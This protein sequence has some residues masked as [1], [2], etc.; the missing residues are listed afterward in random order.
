MAL[1]KTLEQA[2]RWITIAGVF[3]LPFIV[4]IVSSS[5][6]FPFITGK[7]FAFRIIVEIITGS[8]LALALI[9]PHYRPRRNW[10]LAAFALFAIIMAVAD[11]QGVN[12]FK[13]F[14]SNFER[15]DGWV[16]L[17]HLFLYFTV[18]SSILTDKLWK[19][20]WHVILGSSLLI[21]GYGFL[22]LAGL[23]TIN[24]G[25]VRLDATFGNATYLAVYMLFML[26]LAGLFW[27]RSW[28]E[29]GP[30]RRMG[31]GLVYGA[32]MLI[33]FIIMF[34][35]ATR[36]A[37]LGVLGGAIL[38]A[39]LLVLQHPRSRYA[40]RIG[41]GIAAVVVLSLGFW[42][43]RGSSWVQRIEPLQRIASISLS[44]DT[45][46]SR[47]MNIGMALK[48]FEE[49]PL[50]GWGQENYAI[51]FDKY[52]NPDMY[53]QEPWFDRVHN[54]VFD[55]LVAGGLLGLLGY[56][57]LYA[58]AL[59]ALWRSAA[60]SAIERSII[61]GLLAG[62]LFY[63]LFT[64]DNVTSYI[65]FATVLAYIAFR[66]SEHAGAKRLWEGT[67]AGGGSALPFT[68]IGAVILVW[69]GAWFVNADALAQ[70]RTLL[71]AIAPQQD[72]SQNLAYF[73]QAASYQ[74]PGLQEVREQLAQAAS[75]LA[76][77]SNIPADM[78]Q[79]FFTFAVDQM[80]AQSNVSP[81]DARFPLFLGIL[82]D[83]YGDYGDGQ[84]ALARAHE[85]SPAKQSILFQQ[86]ADAE[87]RGDTA[88][89]LQFLK[90][91]FDLAPAYRDARLYY[92]AVLIKANRE[93]DAQQVL[94]PLMQTGEAADPRIAA[95]YAARG[96][97][98]KIAALWEAHVAAQPTDMQ[99]YFTLAA[100]YYA[101][102]NSSQAIATLQKAEKQ[103]PSIASQAEQFI[104]QIR[105]G[106][107]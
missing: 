41:V 12:P 44:D 36:G 102:G 67:I 89:E 107:K 106:K 95:A 97:Y 75:Q 47:L 84:K 101:E 103:D 19:Y 83:S 57:S 17:A 33:D 26:F 28:E 69:A 64:F 46:A 13:S 25:G 10:Q 29:N 87:A 78:K 93:A 8:W 80:I 68:T 65:L 6:F 105:S 45:T 24:Q 86:A 27:A 96:E 5:L 62:Y 81:M 35:T 85:L 30:G 91:A 23:A 79:Q 48:G 74:A 32:I 2:L 7:N 88:G 70:N 15:M 43:V 22:Q 50:L 55:W 66:A 76:S 18:A 40:W 54:I 1:M 60:F 9:Y 72:I 56:L 39:I 31:P 77:N 38:A 94:A 92:A 90:T 11:A 100:A 71:L 42:A 63:L 53:A 52:Y 98:G 73:K 16:T 51:V 59:W 14:W 4:F 104:A 49:K 58:T 20:L 61:T 37:I 21:A 99:G 34:Y 3:A 82:F